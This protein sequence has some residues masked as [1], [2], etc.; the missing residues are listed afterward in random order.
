MFSGWQVVSQTAAEAGART[1]GLSSEEVPHPPVSEFLNAGK[2][3]PWWPSAEQQLIL[4][5]GPGAGVFLEGLPTLPGG[6]SRC[7]EARGITE[8][9][10]THA[11]LLFEGQGGHGGVQAEHV[12]AQQRSQAQRQAL[13]I[14]GHGAN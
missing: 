8:S 10:P 1:W 3:S 14:S 4:V 7:S 5:S 11:H 9:A 6:C 2:G 12:F 13:H